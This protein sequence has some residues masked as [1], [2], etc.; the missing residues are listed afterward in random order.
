MSLQESAVKEY[1]QDTKCW[2]YLNLSYHCQQKQP[3]ALNSI[4]TAKITF[5]VT[6]PFHKKIHLTKM[7]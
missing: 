3:N 4:Q 5:H 6:P 2:Q 7:V 1:L